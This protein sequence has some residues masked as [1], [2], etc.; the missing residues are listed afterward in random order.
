VAHDRGARRIDF[1]LRNLALIK[2]SL[3]KLHIPLHTII[4][5]I[6]TTLPSGVISLLKDLNCTS[7]YANIEYE[8]DELRRD[9][10]VCELAKSSGIRA[11]FL[12]NKCI[13]EPGLVKTKENKAYAVSTMSV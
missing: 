13:V 7:L 11:T 4:H 3:S 8:V 10:K 2:E 1:T 12:H 9:F 6:R 5:D